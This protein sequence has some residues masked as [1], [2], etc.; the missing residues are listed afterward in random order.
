MGACDFTSHATGATAD[1]AFDKAHSAAQYDSGHGGYT[2]TIAEKSGF[3]M[4]NLPEGVTTNEQIEKWI[5][6]AYDDE[7][8]LG[9][10]YSDKWGPAAAVKL[11]DGSFL[12]FGL[13]SS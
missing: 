1:E 5:G 2:G 9:E 6:D 12:F 13:A 8:P 3:V 10:I 4:F 7:G 11:P